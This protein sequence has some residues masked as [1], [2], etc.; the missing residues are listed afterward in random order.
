MPGGGDVSADAARA[1]LKAADKDAETQEMHYRLEISKQTEAARMA[2]KNV[3]SNRHF[4][5]HE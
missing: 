2:K 4:C 5:M 3:R 1:A